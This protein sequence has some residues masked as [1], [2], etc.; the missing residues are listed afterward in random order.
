MNSAFITSYERDNE[1]D[2][3]FAEARYYNPAHGRFTAVDPLMASAS[4]S[5]PQT[6]NRY[7]YV[8]N[9]PLNIT[10][11][12]GL[13]WYS[14][15]GENGSTN[16]RWY[17]SDPGEAWNRVQD[18]TYNAGEG[19]GY[20]ALD[21][22]SANWTEGHADN[23]TAY[24]TISGS[25]VLWNTN[26]L[27]AGV[28]DTLSPTGHFVRNQ[29]A[30]SFGFDNNINERSTPYV[31]GR[32]TGVVLEFAVSTLAG[33]LAG[34]AE[35]GAGEAVEVA[36]ASGGRIVANSAKEFKSLVNQLSKP[37]SRLSSQELQQLEKLAGE[38]GGKLRYDLNPVK[39]K[40]LQPHVQVEGL[41]SK[42]GNRHIWLGDGVK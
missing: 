28:N 26:Q 31:G 33:G 20:V 42:V 12:T 35:V 15:Q 8:G 24:N 19:H 6:W 10:D 36:A 16:Y 7:S 23:A 40:L 39:G 22:Y 25:V 3:D 34:A 27:L 17:V 2:L 30:A 1:S 29:F 38:F 41:G 14:Q 37:T 18:F 9:N 32:W 21:P 13:S 11:P 4:P 5:N